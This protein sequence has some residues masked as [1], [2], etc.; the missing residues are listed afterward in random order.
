MDNPAPLEIQ[1]PLQ[2]SRR[3]LWQAGAL[4]LLL[5]VAVGAYT[6][7]TLTSSCEVTAVKEASDFLLSQ[8]KR[9]DQVYRVTAD[10]S[11]TSV[12]LPVT[13]LQQIFLDT[14]ETVVPAC[15]RTAKNELT[16]YMET[17]IRAFQ[18]Y[19]AGEAN[20]TVIDLVRQSD[21]HYTNFRAELDAVNKCAP[22]CFP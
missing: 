15:V 12:L 8:S 13:I 16:N 19:A 9:Y 2:K 4:I 5:I 17:V 14:Q 7:Y 1:P 10:A 20:T 21:E 11:R 6:W 18:A 3:F 22:F